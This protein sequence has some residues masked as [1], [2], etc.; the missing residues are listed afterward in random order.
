VENW[1]ITFYL[2]IL[3]GDNTKSASQERKEV[4]EEERRTVGICFFPGF[5]FL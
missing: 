2:Q 4:I 5:L 3:G 1:N